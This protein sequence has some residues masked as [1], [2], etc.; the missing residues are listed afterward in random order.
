VR[1]SPDTFEIAAFAAFFR[2]FLFFRFHPP[3]LANRAKHF[4]FLSPS[5]FF[6]LDLG[7]AKN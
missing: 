6:G 4:H 7:K 5:R 1:L 3:E 2:P